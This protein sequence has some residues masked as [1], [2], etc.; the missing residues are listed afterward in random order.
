MLIFKLKI[1]FL[2][3]PISGLIQF[4][5]AERSSKMMKNAFFILKALLST[6]YLKLCHDSFG[7]VGMQFD[8][9]A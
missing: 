2:A 1:Q 7:H 4:L 9:K 8:K 3:G 5:A 6:R